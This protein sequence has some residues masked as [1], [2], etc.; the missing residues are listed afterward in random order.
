MA[1]QL[2]T[3]GKGCATEG[4]RGRDELELIKAWATDDGRGPN[5]V[6]PK[7]WAKDG[8]GRSEV[9][10]AVPPPCSD[11]AR[12]LCCKDASAARKR[13][14]CA[15]ADTMTP[16]LGGNGT[17]R[18]PL[19]AQLEVLPVQ[20]SILNS[21]SWNRRDR[22]NHFRDLPRLTIC[23]AKPSF[24]PRRRRRR[25]RQRRRRRRQQRRRS[26]CWAASEPMRPAPRCCR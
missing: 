12:L 10:A 2:P 11:E 21:C 3:L 18:A 5:E 14:S 19:M 13:S 17:D 8:R 1:S 16:T 7:V 15:D 4:G 9:V 24:S 25:K 22:K 23:D 26:C 20:R 6:E